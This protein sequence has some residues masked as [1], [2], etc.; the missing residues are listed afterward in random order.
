MSTSYCKE[1]YP[2]IAECQGASHTWKKMIAVR[3][4]EELNMWWQLK[5]E[6]VNFWF[7]NW[8]K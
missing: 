3:E 7:N 6:E 4:E 8:T 1:L 2:V 5:E